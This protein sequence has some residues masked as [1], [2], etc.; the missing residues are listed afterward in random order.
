MSEEEITHVFDDSQGLIVAVAEW[1]VACMEK[2]PNEKFSLALSGGTTPKPLYE[3]L[4]TTY[5]DRIN[6]ERVHLFWNDERF[7]PADHAQSNYHMTRLALIDRVPIPAANVHPIITQ[8]SFPSDTPAS[9]AQRYAEVLQAYYGASQLDPKR[10][11]FTVNLL[12]IGDDGHTASLFPGMPQLEET[13]AWAVPVQ[14]DSAQLGAGAPPQTTALATPR[15]LTRISLARPVLES[16]KTVIF[17]AVG[18]NKHAAV[19]KARA[20]DDSIPAGCIRSQ[21]ELI[22]FLDHE[23][24]YG[25]SG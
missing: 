17:L 2:N 22:W 9:A 11:L 13:Q 1:L 7:V 20:R 5:V 3:L 10:P 4:A 19:S 16:A 14:L 6:W 23:A 15:P 21:G 25:T 8:D 18:G 12:G 24:A